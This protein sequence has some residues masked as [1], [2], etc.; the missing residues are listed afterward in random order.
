[1][2]C[3]FLSFSLDSFIYPPTYLLVQYQLKGSRDGTVVGARECIA[4]L[5]GD[6]RERSSHIG[7]FW[8]GRWV[9][10]W[11]E[12]PTVVGWVG[13]WVGGRKGIRELRT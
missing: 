2:V 3:I 9:G 10:G 11:V 12:R 1:M 5:I 7:C 6:E 8:I 13:G 4:H